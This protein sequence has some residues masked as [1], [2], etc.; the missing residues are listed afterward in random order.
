MHKR[1]KGELMAL[2]GSLVL[3]ALAL[4]GIG[5][6]FVVVDLL[7]KQ[8]SEFLANQQAL[9][10]SVS[11]ALAQAPRPESFLP[12]A[13]NTQALTYA[14]AEPAPAPQVV[15]PQWTKSS[16]VLDGL[17][18]PYNPDA[19][20]LNA[21]ANQQKALN[22]EVGQVY[23][24][25]RQILQMVPQGGALI[26]VLAGLFDILGQEVNKMNRGGFDDLSPL[27]RKRF[28]LYG[29]AGKANPWRSQQYDPKAEKP[30]P[31][32]GY[33]QYPERQREYETAFA[34]WLR[35][36]L[37]GGA[38][39]A[40]QL[41]IQR[42]G[43]DASLPAIVIDLLIKENEW[44]PPLEPL[45]LTK[46]EWL[47]RRSDPG[48]QYPFPFHELNP[49]DNLTL[50]TYAQIRAEYQADAARFANRIAQL[51]IPAEIRDLART[52][53]SWPRLGSRAAPG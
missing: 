38:R 53:G 37:I 19:A 26:G 27:A 21:V 48:R 52:A 30:E 22:S 12:A 47:A 32:K 2:L 13:P 51:G 14:P 24:A 1:K 18:D 25:T 42:T 33:E 23:S 17:P 34:A 40:E 9:L 7:R 36:W 28:L 39:K 49:A 20:R 46:A 16:V 31:L 6:T 3:G 8:R 29:L 4:L 44:P 45:P 5:G 15:I 50:A 41:R 35:S 43:D 11:T 10:S